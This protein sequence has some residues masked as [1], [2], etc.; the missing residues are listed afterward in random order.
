MKFIA[1]NIA[2]NRFDIS[3][4]QSIKSIPSPEKKELIITNYIAAYTQVKHNFRV[5]NC[6]I[7]NIVKKLKKKKKRFNMHS[8]F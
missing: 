7:H 3:F 4:K 5:N 2:L 8:K 6:G 1:T